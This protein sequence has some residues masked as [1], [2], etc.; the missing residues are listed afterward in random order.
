VRSAAP[1]LAAE[2]AH[3]RT[4]GA[5]FPLRLRLE[6]AAFMLTWALLAAWTPPFLRAWR[7]QLLRMFGARLGRGANVYA[8]VRI[9]HPRY[10]V[11]ADYATLGPRVHCYN[12]ALVTLG[13]YATVSQDTT[14]CAGTHDHE[15]ADFQLHARPI[16]L[17]PEC[18]IAAE[19]FVG[20]GVHVGAGAVLGARGVAMR[21]LEPGMVYAGNP[22]VPIKRRVRA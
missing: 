19:A 3:P 6:R 11:M 22:A 7:R 21:D 18:W 16:T 4:G 13:A 9:W 5:S 1:I 14:L 20:P 15:D 12:Q 8:S 10:L 17:G 2:Q